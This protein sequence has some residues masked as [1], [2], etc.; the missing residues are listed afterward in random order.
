MDE[1]EGADGSPGAAAD[2][3]WAEVRRA[4][5]LSGETVVSIQNRFG[6]T[7]YKLT[8]QRVAEG[9]TTRLPVAKPGPRPRR[10]SVGSEVLGFRLNRLLIIGVAMLDKR[11][12]EEGMTEANARM[13]T[14]LCRAEELRMR[15]TRTKTGKTRETKNHDAGYDFRDDPA[16]LR[17]ELN[18][19]L[20]RL[21]RRSKAGG[22]PRAADAGGDA[23]P[24]GG[25]AKELGTG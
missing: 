4:Y 15:S 2:V 7:Q 25:L 11:L 9:W 20:D 1:A 24:S 13:A 3:D 22:D 12:I 8:K 6:L 23:G 21:S 10:K 18:R 17:A 16:W 14:E 5:E 19:R